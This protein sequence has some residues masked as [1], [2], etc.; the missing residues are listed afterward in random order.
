M[1]RLN[2]FAV[3]GMHLHHRSCLTTSSASTNPTSVTNLSPLPPPSPR[4]PPQPPS[5]FCSVC[6][7]F[8]GPPAYSPTPPHPTHCPI[9]SAYVLLCPGGVLSY[10]LFFASHSLLD[11]AIIYV[12]LASAVS[13][14]HSFD[15]GRKRNLCA[16]RSCCV[17][18]GH[19]VFYCSYWS[20]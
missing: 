2:H 12:E 7:L 4:F 19:I 11:E 3:D 18:E 17:G 10:A 9:T 13:V 16:F 8:I 20:G 15:R 14:V 5:L 6:V 1:R